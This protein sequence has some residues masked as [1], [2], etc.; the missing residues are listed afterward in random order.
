[1]T[2]LFQ[3]LIYQL[4]SCGVW[5][6]ESVFAVIYQWFL[7][8]GHDQHSNMF[9]LARAL[10]TLKV[11]RCHCGVW[12][13]LGFIHTLGSSFGNQTNNYGH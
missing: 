7:S 1:M 9:P 3:F 6:S 12:G 10:L 4:V 13:V 8:H 2:Y 5:R 11:M